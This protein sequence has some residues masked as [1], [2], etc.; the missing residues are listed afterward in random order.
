LPYAEKLGIAEKVIR[1][2]YGVIEGE[3]SFPMTHFGGTAAYEGGK[4]ATV[5]G[6]MGNAQTHC[7]QLPNIFAFA[8]GATGKTLTEAD[9]VSFA[10]DLIPGLGQD[11][12]KGW[13]LLNGKDAAAMHAQAEVLERAAAKKPKSG[14][15][16]GLLFQDPHRFLTDL[17]LML[18]MRA[19]E[20]E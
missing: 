3:P 17:V 5:R 1:F 14:P 8:R 16:K 10:N 15:L 9:Y 18:H 11:I 6:V 13:Q 4:A 12:V 19:A 7:V 20:E 2:N